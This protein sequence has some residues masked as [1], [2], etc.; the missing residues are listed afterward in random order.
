MARAAL[1]SLLVVVLL[2]TVSGCGG[3]DDPPAAREPGRDLRDLESQTVDKA[4]R[5]QIERFAKVSIPDDATSLRSATHSAMDTQLLVSFRIPRS[6]LQAFVR[7]GDFHAKLVEGNRAIAT[8]IGEEIGWQLE[9]A[10]RVE[11]LADTQTGLYRNVVVVL[12]DPRHPVV[13]M[14]AGT[15]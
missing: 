12:D 7:S 1:A 5:A 10:K 3:S 15:L 14:E 11:G 13:H 9:D 6:E 2:L 4:T 8:P